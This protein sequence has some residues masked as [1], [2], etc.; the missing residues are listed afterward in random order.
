MTFGSP[1]ILY[2]ASVDGG[3]N[4]GGTVLTLSLANGAWT[5]STLYAF[6]NNG[7]GPVGTPALDQAGNIYNIADATFSQ[8]RG[9]WVGDFQAS[10]HSGA[11]WTFTDLHDFTDTDGCLSV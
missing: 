4:D 10:T 1:N 8:G 6:Q 2:G 11:N 3:Q 9:C 7:G 5:E